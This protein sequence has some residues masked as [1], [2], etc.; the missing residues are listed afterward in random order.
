M[1][2]YRGEGGALYDQVVLCIRD[3]RAQSENAE[4]A[5]AKA[6]TAEE[7]REALVAESARACCYYSS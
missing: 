5:G 3:G 6:S 4:Y 1:A 7:E 2:S